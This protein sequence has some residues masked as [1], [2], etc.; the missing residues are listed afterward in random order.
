[1]KTIAIHLGMVLGQNFSI[2]TPF[3]KKTF[4]VFLKILEFIAGFRMFFL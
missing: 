2:M 1:M 3:K 4:A